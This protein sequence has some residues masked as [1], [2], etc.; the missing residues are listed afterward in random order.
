MLPPDKEVFRDPRTASRV[1]AGEAVVLT[2]RD[3][4]ILTLN[5]TGTRIWELLADGPTIAEIA[6][7]LVQEFEIEADRARQDV[8]AFI[9]HLLCREIATL[10]RPRDDDDD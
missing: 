5:E 7:V 2:P 6:S 4:R 3:G 8:A 1:I 10:E 9:D